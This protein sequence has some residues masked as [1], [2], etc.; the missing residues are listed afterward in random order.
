[1]RVLVSPA[2]KHGGTAQIGR[3]MA[4]VLRDNG[5]DVDVTQPEDINDLSFYDGFVIGSA[6]YMGS[7]LPAAREFVH[8]HRSGLRRKPTWLFSSGPL[9]DS[10]PKEP[11]DPD[12]LASLTESSNAISHRLFGGRLEL[13]RLSRTERFV[14][15]WVGATDGDHREWDEI[16]R[17]T[18]EIAEALK[19]KAAPA[20]PA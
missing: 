15:H 19:S 20:E 7:W 9:G 16:D 10:K 8:E 13:H 11:I 1:M 12:V 18:V 5:I 14:A 2:S 3:E 17:W 6:L 4:R